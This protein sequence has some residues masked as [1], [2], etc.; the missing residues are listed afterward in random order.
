MCV[1]APGMQYLTVFLEYSWINKWIT[2]LSILLS[3][4]ILQYLEHLKFATYQYPSFTLCLRNTER[5]QK[6]QPNRSCRTCDIAASWGQPLGWIRKALRWLLW[7][8]HIVVHIYPILP[9][10]FCQIWIATCQGQQAPFLEAS[11]RTCMFRSFG[12]TTHTRKAFRIT[13]T[14]CTSCTC[15]DGR[16]GCVVRAR[17]R[18]LPKIL[19]V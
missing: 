15:R 16:G 14:S 13:A 7:I 6:T 17:L 8:C 4:I 1:C 2:I 10:T 11:N 3:W 5:P 18:S 19:Y 12:T 9:I